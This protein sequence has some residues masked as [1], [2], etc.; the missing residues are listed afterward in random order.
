LT[1]LSPVHHRSSGAT[2]WP[3]LLVQAAKLWRSYSSPKRG[4]REWFGDS[5]EFRDSLGAGRRFVDSLA[6]TGEPVFDFLHVLLPHRPWQYLAGGRTYP[7]R[8]GENARPPTW[9]SASA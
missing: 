6:E 2:G 3:P 5:R 4:T 1:Q 9:H 7:L 8:K